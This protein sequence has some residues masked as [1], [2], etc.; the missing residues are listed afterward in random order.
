MLVH[1][2]VMENNIKTLSIKNRTRKYLFLFYKERHKLSVKK[3]E[4]LDVIT[5]YATNDPFVIYDFY[6]VFK[7]T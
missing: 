7:K 2:Y 1:S 6:N 3:L 5:Q 4:L